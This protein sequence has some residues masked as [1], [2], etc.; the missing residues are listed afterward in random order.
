MAT[1]TPASRT[2]LRCD[3]VVVSAAAAS[4]PEVLPSAMVG[5]VGL[6]SLVVKG[7]RRCHRSA[8]C[9]SGPAASNAMGVVTVG[10]PVVAS[11]GRSCFGFG[12]TV[13]EA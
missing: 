4:W 9:F 1:T 13:G 3:D 7:S 2:S 10:P 11:P 12:T 8:T 5:T 6:G